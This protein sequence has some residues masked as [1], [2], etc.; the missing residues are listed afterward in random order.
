MSIRI[1][2]I[3][4]A[5]GDHENPYV[6]ISQLGWTN[7]ASGERGKSTRIEMYDFVRKGGDAFVESAGSKAQLIAAETSR[8]TKYVKTAANSTQAD[9]LLKLLECA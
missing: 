9:N 3:N 5:S 4:K 7:P 8:G 6:A 2:C 1:H